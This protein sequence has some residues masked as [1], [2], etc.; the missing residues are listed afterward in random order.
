MS[1]FSEFH[2]D[3]RKAF[4]AGEIP[5]DFY[6]KVTAECAYE[7]MVDGELADAMYLVAKLPAEWLDNVMPQQAAEDTVFGAHI[8]ALAENLIELGYVIDGPGD[9]TL[10][11]PVTTNKTAAS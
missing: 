8:L 11:M 5:A 6:F 3:M 10:T 1:Q 9:T 2:N 4:R 7:M